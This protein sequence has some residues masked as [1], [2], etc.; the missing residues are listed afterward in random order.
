MSVI[1]KDALR[2]ESLKPLEINDCVTIVIGD[3]RT[4]QLLVKSSFE[5]SGL[6]GWSPSRFP[7]F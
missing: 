5:P 1:T 3:D 4:A 2:C 7:Q 6:E